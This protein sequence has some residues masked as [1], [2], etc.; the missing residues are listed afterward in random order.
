MDVLLRA[1]RFVTEK[2]P[3]AVPRVHLRRSRVIVNRHLQPH[4]C[5]FFFP[6]PLPFFSPRSA[7][8]ANRF[9]R[10]RFDT[11]PRAH[12]PSKRKK[13]PTRYESVSYRVIHFVAKA[14]ENIE[15]FASASNSRP[16]L[17]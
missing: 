11:L 14:A 1:A 5:G 13:Y 8:A 17:S 6:P 16:A 12:S 15:R 9:P 4:P 3:R 2:R 10:E 7:A